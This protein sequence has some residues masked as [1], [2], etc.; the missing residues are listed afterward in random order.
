MAHLA[1]RCSTR[2]GW[3]GCAGRPRWRG[4]ARVSLTAAAGT[5]HRDCSCKA[6]ALPHHRLEQPGQLVDLGVLAGMVDG[7]GGGVQQHRV[8]REVRLDPVTATA[9][10]TPHTPSVGEQSR[11]DA[12]AA[13]G[14]RADGTGGRR[15]GGWVRELP[16]LSSSSAVSPLEEQRAVERFDLLEGLEGAGVLA[17]PAGLADQEVDRRLG[18]DRRW[19]G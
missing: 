8:G 18:A 10:K 2:R 11:A 14:G 3:A 1:A 13:G 5:I 4:R 17:V 9:A 6:V 12:A 15:S 16:F 19:W 7:G